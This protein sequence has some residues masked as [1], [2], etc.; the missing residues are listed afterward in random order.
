MS[1][2]FLLGPARQALGNRIDSRD[3]RML[4]GGEHGVA[5]AVERRSETLLAFAQ[6]LLALSQCLLC[7]S[8]LGNVAEDQHRT[9]GR[10]VLEIP[11]GRT[12]VRKRARRT[13]ARDDRRAAPKPDAH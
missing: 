3:P 11:D 4:I 6:P 1:D 5:D 13:A 9:M 8:L 12:A 10:A 2:G 7:A